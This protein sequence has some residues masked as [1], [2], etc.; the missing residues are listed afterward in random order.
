MCRIVKHTVKSTF[1]KPFT[2][3][4]QKGRRVPIKFQLFVNTELKN[5]LDENHIIKLK[6]CSDKKFISPIVIY[7]KKDK[8]VNLA[9]DSTI[10]NKS[11]RKNKYKIPNIDNLIDTIKQS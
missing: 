8:T 5:F 3:T 1:H 10:L 4:H 6:S 2:P 7:V 11:I 9:L